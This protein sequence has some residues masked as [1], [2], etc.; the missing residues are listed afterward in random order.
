MLPV[1]F[2]WSASRAAREVWVRR[3]AGFGFSLAVVPAVVAGGRQDLM[4]WLQKLSKSANQKVGL[5]TRVRGAGD[6]AEEAAEARRS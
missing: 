5:Q 1:T 3:E 6:L 2:R 4:D